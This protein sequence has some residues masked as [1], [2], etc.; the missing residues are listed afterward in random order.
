[1]QLI[2]LH[3]LKLHDMQGN[4][5]CVKDQG[6]SDFEA[7][8]IKYVDNTIAPSTRCTRSGLMIGLNTTFSDY[9]SC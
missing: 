3:E 1:M 6:M 7:E 2:K 5:K 8:S 4:E 9:I